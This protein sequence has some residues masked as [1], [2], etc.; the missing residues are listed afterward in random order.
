MLE[1]VSTLAD[2]MDIDAFKAGLQADG[3]DEI[4]E[5][6]MTAGST[7]EEHTHPFD[8]RALVL[9]GEAE[10]SC[11]G[12]TRVYRKG[13]VLTMAADTPHVE[14]YAAGEDYRFLVGR[15]HRS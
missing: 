5:R 9:A 7:I 12:E 6:T 1:V 4:L 11:G 8:V 14:R 2:I 10:I 13:D 15:R 3:Y